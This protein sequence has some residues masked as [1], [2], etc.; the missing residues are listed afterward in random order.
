MPALLRGNLRQS[1][2]EMHAGNASAPPYTFGRSPATG[3][4]HHADGV[5]GFTA[6]GQTVMTISPDVVDVQG[7]LSGNAAGLYD[8]SAANVSGLTDALDIIDASSVT[9]NVLTVD[10]TATATAFV[11]DGS[12]LAGIQAS[13]VDGLSDAIDTIDNSSVTTNVLT[14]DGS[15]TVGGHILPSANVTYDVGSTIQRFRDLYLSGNTIDLAGALIQAL[16]GNVFIQNLDVGSI[17]GDGSG[18][19][20]IKLPPSINTIT[21]TNASWTPIDDTALSTTTTGYLVIDGANFQTETNVSIGGTAAASV[22]LVN[23]TL[24]RVS[25]NPKTTGTYDVVVETGGGSF[26]KINAVSFDPVPVWSTNSSLGD[27]YY[28]NAFSITLSATD[29]A[30]YT[31]TSSL[32]PSITLA[33]NGVLQGSITATSS[34]TYNF[35]VEAI[36]AQLQSA[37]RS[38][39]LVYNYFT[40]SGGAV[41]TNGGYTY[42]RFT[43]NGTLTVS[44]GGVIEYLV[45]GGGGGG[46]D[47]PGG[48]GGAG[49]V[50]QG[51]VL[52]SSGS[53]AIVIGTGGT[54]G[55]GSTGASTNGYGKNGTSTTFNGLTAIGGGGGG[56]YYTSY[57]RDGA[58]GGGGGG[59]G[60]FGGTGLAGY[61]GG[62]GSSGAGGG[63]GGGGAGGVGGTT[64]TY[65]GGN[66]GPG[67]VWGPY[68]VGGG[69][70]GSAHDGSSA[71]G[72]ATH[73]GGAGGKA[74][75]VDG[76]NATA[77]TGG[78]GG[79]GGGNN[80]TDGYGGGQGG[81]GVVI[82]RYL[83]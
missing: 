23:S 65:N 67:I 8:V 48:G 60:G 80:T 68:S 47:A 29:A 2:I 50:I 13:N 33:S 75:T 63:S 37:I 69:G 51:S 28:S 78:G 56:N 24:L 70:G 38:F 46:G 5:L 82:I 52:L 43:S 53:Y 42:R 59:Y 4:Y 83:A 44:S 61:D 10:G 76:Y 20:G 17:R 25:V 26:T 66:G 6:N 32:P 64:T 62:D 73:G 22:T 79:G 72:S 36:D 57:G 81:S 41:T 1:G 3:L 12:G 27:V 54:G 35:S 40:A 74:H 34:T 7:V 31:A 45:V 9:T 77:N 71:G 19:T 21:I 30:T 18:I 55:V 15:T 11:G 39:S 14:V 49:Q 16:G 58:S